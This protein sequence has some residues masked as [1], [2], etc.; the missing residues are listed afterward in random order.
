MQ[1]AFSNIYPLMFEHVVGHEHHRHIPRG[2]R[3]LALAAEALLQGRE[4][5]WA[6]V[7]EGENL[8]VEHDAIGERG[9]R[10]DDFGKLAR[11]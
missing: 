11:D 4:R 1:W 10:V 7:P 3:H 5:Q 9:S 8:A 2:A 6:A